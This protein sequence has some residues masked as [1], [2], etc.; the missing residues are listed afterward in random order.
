[1]TREELR[2][3]RDRAAAEATARADALVGSVNPNR[4]TVYRVGAESDPLGYFTQDMLNNAMSG[5]EANAIYQ[6]THRQN[7]ARN[8]RYMPDLMNQFR[9][10]GLKPG[11]TQQYAQPIGGYDAYVA[12]ADALLTPGFDE[13]LPAGQG[14]TEGIPQ[15]MLDEAGKRQAYSELLAALVGGGY[16]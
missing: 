12:G 9:E 13:L 16:R 7:D 2:A 6:A 11:T 14:S 1:M 3:L 8:Y 15:W 5:P 10:E 4:D